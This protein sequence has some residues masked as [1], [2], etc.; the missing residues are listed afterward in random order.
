MERV[1]QP[2]DSTII[3]YKNPRKVVFAKQ[4]YKK[5]SL[6]KKIMF[7]VNIGIEGSLVGFELWTIIILALIGLSYVLP[8]EGLFLGNFIIYSALFLI[9]EWVIIAYL[10]YTTNSFAKIWP[11]IMWAGTLGPILYRKHKIVMK[12]WYNTKFSIMLPSFMFIDYK[13]T[14][15]WANYKKI[16]IFQTP[17]GDWQFDIFLNKIVE[18]GQMT[19]KL[20]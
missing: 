1:G 10:S 11:T 7:N 8:M 4:P 3:I 17:I 13:L 15:D 16:K 20:S 19:L 9:V 14:G 2:V 18:K 6:L 5:Y 12:H